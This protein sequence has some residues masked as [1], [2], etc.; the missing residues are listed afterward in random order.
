VGPSERDLRAL[1]RR[2]QPPVVVRLSSLLN[3]SAWLFVAAVAVG[4]LVR[5]AVT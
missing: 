1:L 2:A 4:A 3:A 5:E